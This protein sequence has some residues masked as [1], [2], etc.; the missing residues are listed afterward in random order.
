MKVLTIVNS[1]GM[2]G[3]EK[4]LL[5]CVPYLKKKGIDLYVC[6]LEKDGFLE[7]DFLKHGVKILKIKKTNSIV[8]DFLQIMQIIKENNINLIHSRFGFSSGGYVLACLFSSIPSIVSI[9]NTH[10]ARRK[11]F[12]I[13]IIQSYSLFLHKVITINLASKIV[14][15]SKANLN[16]NYL[17][18]QSKNK[19]RLIYN[20][21][22]FSKMDTYKTEVYDEFRKKFNDKDVILHIGSFRN[23]KNHKFLLKAFSKLD[24]IVNNKVLILI[25]DG[26]LKQNILSLVKELNIE[27]NVIFTGNQKELGRYFDVSSI[28]FF[29]S[30][31]EGFGN[32][33][34]EAQYMN[35]PVCGSDILPLNESI[36]PDYA[37]YRFNPY[38]IEEAA[39]KLKEI[40]NDNNSGKLEK[41][42]IEAS[43]FVKRNF[44]IENM[45]NKL[46][47]LYTEIQSKKL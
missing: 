26:P 10:P 27:S 38:N 46:I 12:F 32:V 45:A 15:H 16:S 7:E 13:R 25:G 5:L 43:N 23:Q 4:T 19:F 31:H 36:Y 21:I 29:P 37:K 40:I 14:G 9:H 47:E 6:V 8:L 35:I 44:A 42:K 28:L 20:G 39:L 34:L 22:N 1:L 30:M 2:G 17:S 3:I 24:P 33:I 18:W 11:N 41:S